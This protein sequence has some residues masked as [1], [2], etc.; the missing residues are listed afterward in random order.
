MTKYDHLVCLLVFLFET[1]NL[2]CYGLSVAFHY[3]ILLLFVSRF[4][5]IASAS[6]AFPLVL[7]IS[8]LQA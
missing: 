6:L 1:D 4:C 5:G 8:D 3:Y 7:I 2:V